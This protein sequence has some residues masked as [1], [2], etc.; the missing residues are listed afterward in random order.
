MEINGASLNSIY[1][2]MNKLQNTKQVSNDNDQDNM[3]KTIQSP[4]AAYR[5]DNDQDDMQ[6]T[7]RSKM[8]IGK[9]IN[10]I[11]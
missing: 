10:T 1:G 11:A 5:N 7:Y 8:G 3:I 6:N 9:N 2:G 4:K